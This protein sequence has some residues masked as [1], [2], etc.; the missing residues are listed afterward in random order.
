MLAL[1]DLLYIV[2]NM[3]YEHV[4]NDHDFIEFCNRRKLKPNSVLQYRHALGIYSELIGKSLSELLKEA[5]NEEDQGIRI[6]NRTIRKHLSTFQKHIE[7]K[8]YSDNSKKVFM[9]CVRAYYNEYEI[10]LPKRFKISPRTDKKEKKYEDLPTIEDIRHLLKYANLM[11]TAAILLGLSSGMSR[12]E[13]CSLTIKDFC[14]AIDLK[15]FP[16]DF[17]ELLERVKPLSNTVPH[18][19]ITRQK[20]ENPFFTFSTPEATEAIINHIDDVNRRNKRLVSHPKKNPIKLTPETPLFISN[21]MNQMSV[22]LLTLSYQRMNEKA[23]FEKVGNSSFIRPHILREVF[24]STLEKNKMPHLMTRW[25]LAH[26]L[27]STTSAYFK[28][29]PESVKEEYVQFMD[30][31]TTNQKIEVKTVTASGYDQLLKD[32]KEKEEK[33]KSMELKLKKMEEKIKERDKVLDDLLVEKDFMKEVQ[34][35]I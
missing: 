28:A 35:R 14:D 30:Q 13:I 18:W 34:K 32:S 7:D 1:Y 8:N 26:K 10:Q 9:T 25:L 29:D 33:L 6:R 2:S 21:Q 24:A 20:T 22:T 15:P 27:D 11:C 5:E 3:K 4:T 19:Q 16:E 23:G 31:L 12:A 17:D